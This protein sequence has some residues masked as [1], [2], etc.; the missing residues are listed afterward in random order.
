M[1]ETKIPKADGLGNIDPYN[2]ENMLKMQD[3]L[4][5]KKIK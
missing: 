3:E 2:D 4:G 5:E 1:D